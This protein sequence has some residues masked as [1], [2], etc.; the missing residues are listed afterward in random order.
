MFGS[1]PPTTA[2]PSDDP[3][4]LSLSFLQSEVES[5]VEVLPV[6]AV[7]RDDRRLS[8]LGHRPAARRVR[9]RHARKISRG[10]RMKPPPM[11]NMPESRP[12]ASPMPSSM[13]RFSD[14]SAIGR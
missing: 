2:L 3:G 10:V 6:A 11:P 8:E 14:I 9:G 1:A 13:N 12:T 5:W 7:G 4:D